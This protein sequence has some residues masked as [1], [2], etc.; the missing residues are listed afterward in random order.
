MSFQFKVSFSVAFSF[1]PAE[2]DGIRKEI[3]R[4]NCGD[5]T[6]PSSVSRRSS[7]PQPVSGIQ[8][9]TPCNPSRPKLRRFELFQRASMPITGDDPGAE[10]ESAKANDR[11][12]LKLLLQATSHAKG[13]TKNIES[14]QA[15]SSRPDDFSLVHQ[16]P[17]AP[18][19]ITPEDPSVSGLPL[20]L[21]FDSGSDLISSLQ[22]LRVRGLA[23]YFEEMERMAALRPSLSSR[24]RVER[25]AFH[26]VVKDDDEAETVE[27]ETWEEMTGSGVSHG[28][29]TER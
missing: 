18:S 26:D 6:M 23:S 5:H 19:S 16:I 21:P 2:E 13:S 29:L 27:L 10:T 20:D 28:G 25:D 4:E 11:E 3:Q 7:H 17:G 1:G 8:S 22:R 24:K 15:T 12:S 9:P 14:D